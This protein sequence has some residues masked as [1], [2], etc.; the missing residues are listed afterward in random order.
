MQ[1]SR[2]LQE[3][4]LPLSGAGGEVWGNLVSNTVTNESHN[5]VSALMITL[6]DLKG[7]MCLPLPE[8]VGS[9]EDAEG[10]AEDPKERL[11]ILEGK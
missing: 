10:K 4:M 2:F 3:V 9:G 8:S 1:L 11:H 5:F 6:G 7:K